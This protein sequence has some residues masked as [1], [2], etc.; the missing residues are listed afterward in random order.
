MQTKTE[1]TLKQPQQGVSDEV[2]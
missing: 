1:L 2:L